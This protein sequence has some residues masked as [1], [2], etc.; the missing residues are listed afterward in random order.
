MGTGQ[1]RGSMTTQYVMDPLLETMDLGGSTNFVYFGKAIKF[2]GN[3][4]GGVHF[5]VTVVTVLLGF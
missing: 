5:S 2:R 1:P 3:C 4:I